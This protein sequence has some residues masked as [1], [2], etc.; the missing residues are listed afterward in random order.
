LLSELHEFYEVAKL[1][2]SESI[3]DLGRD[4]IALHY[5]YGYDSSRR[6]NLFF[7]EDNRIIYATS[8]SVVLENV[9]TGTREFVLGID[10]GGV[11]AV[12]VHPSR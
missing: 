10:E 12:A 2:K 9:V 11:G 7:I 1:R 5:A 3:A 6:C 8:S 4:S